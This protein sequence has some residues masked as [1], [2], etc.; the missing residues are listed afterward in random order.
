ML[1]EDAIGKLVVPAAMAVHS[2]LGP[3]LLESAY[4]ACLAHELEKHGLNV[5]RQVVLPVVYDGL[6]LNVGYRRDLLVDGKV[7]IELK[8]VE[9]FVPIHMAQLLSYL[10]LGKFKLG[11]LLNFNVVHM[12]DGVKRL[13]N[14]L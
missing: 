13:V 1:N 8:S 14:G 2:Q 6:K 4:E 5:G 9:K 3:G 7:V 10:K 11:F 12:R